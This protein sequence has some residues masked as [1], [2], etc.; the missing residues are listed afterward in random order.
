MTLILH[1]ISLKIFHSEL[2]TYNCLL[3]HYK[4]TQINIFMLDAWNLDIPIYGNPDI[5]T[6]N[7]N[8]LPARTWRV[9]AGTESQNYVSFSMF[10]TLSPH[11]PPILSVQRRDHLRPVQEQS[12]GTSHSMIFCVGLDDCSSTVTQCAVLFSLQRDVPQGIPPYT[13]TR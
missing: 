3:F 6:S 4:F 7:I 10:P 12:L 13:G 2:K 5:H 8:F 11:P 9:Q 1:C